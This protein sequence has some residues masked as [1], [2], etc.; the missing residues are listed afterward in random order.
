VLLTARQILAMANDFIAPG[1]MEPASAG[2][3]VD[4]RLALWAE[5]VDVSEALLL[6]GLRRTIGPDGDLREAYRRWYA[7]QRAEHERYLRLQ[8]ANLYRRGV[9]HG[10]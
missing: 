9:C 7:Q 5:L 8:A 6:A 2:L 10:R 3:S 4:Q 1:G